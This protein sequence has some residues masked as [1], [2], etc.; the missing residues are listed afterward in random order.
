MGI[1]KD[2]KLVHTTELNSMNVMSFKT[3]PHNVASIIFAVSGSE[4]SIAGRKNH[5]SRKMYV[6]H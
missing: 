3:H 4:L 6:I 1:D 5:G 2:L